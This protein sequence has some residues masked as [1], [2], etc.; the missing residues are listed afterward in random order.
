M[1]EKEPELPGYEFEQEGDRDG[2]EYKIFGQYDKFIGILAHYNTPYH[3]K[4]RPEKF[5]DKLFKVIGAEYEFQT[6]D[7]KFDRRFFILGRDDIYRTA[8]KNSEVR[9]RISDLPPFIEFFVGPNCIFLKIKT[10]DQQEFIAVDADA[11]V[12]KL[13]SIGKALEDTA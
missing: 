10:V 6:G 4:L 11:L 13:I 7:K 3:F 1:E 9:K 5:T 12:N 8:L 2:I